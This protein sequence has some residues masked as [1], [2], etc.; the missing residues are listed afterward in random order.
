MASSDLH[1][2]IQSLSKSE[3]RYFRLYCARK[4]GDG[5]YMKL[6]DA[7]GRQ[8]EYDE[9]AIRKRFARHTFVR[10]LHVTKHYL[11]NLILQSL[12]DYHA[13]ISSDARLKDILRNAEILFHK[14]LYT[15]CRKELDRAER[16]ATKY[17][18]LPGM[19]DVQTW[20]RRLTQALHPHAYD[21][22]L[23]TL[24]QQRGAIDTLRSTNEAWRLAIQVSQSMTRSRQE[25]G[26]RNVALKPKP[27]MTLEETVLH[28]NTQYLLDLRSDQNDTA[29][30]QLSNLIAHL[31]ADPARLTEDAGLYVSTVNNLVSFLVFQQRHKEA[32]HLI[33]KAK[34]VYDALKITASNRTLLKQI[35]R[36]YNIEL[37]IYRSELNVTGRDAFVK[38]TETFVIANQQKIPHD[39]LISFWFQLASVNFA[40]QDLERSLEWINRILNARFK[41][42][43]QD[44]VVQTHLLNLLV[45][46][47]QQNFMVL[48]YYVDSARR[49]F[50]KV[51]FSQGYAEQILRFCVSMGRAPVLEYKRMY[52][53]LHRDLFPAEGPSAIPQE[54]DRYIN[55]RAWLAPKVM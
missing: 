7:I 53:A 4:A 33:Q 11:R 27:D 36:T 17:E 21:T 50:K 30:H 45:H 41:K 15:H 26:V 22:F 48:R 28:Y 49:Y 24:Q 18:L 37:E 51:R 20:K 47:E 38:T 3:K 55:Y 44:L 39:Y 43:R 29:E 1:L 16:I 13:G 5:N 35:L 40:A 9:A 31:E 12:R 8:R 2:L 19:I 25:V 34:S 42:L 6:F 32:V 46:L 54:M 14:E 23:D 52:R 10:Q